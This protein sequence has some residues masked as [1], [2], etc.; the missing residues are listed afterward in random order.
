MAQA[1]TFKVNSGSSESNLLARRKHLIPGWRPTW[2]GE[3]HLVRF[4][5]RSGPTQ[6]PQEGCWPHS[7]V[8]SS[9]DKA[10]SWRCLTGSPRHHT[11]RPP[12]LGDSHLHQAVKKRLPQ[13]V[14]FEGD[15]SLW[16]QV[17]NAQVPYNASHLQHRL[18]LQLVLVCPQILSQHHCTRP[19]IHAILWIKNLR[20]IHS[21]LEK[22][23]SKHYTIDAFMW[24]PRHV[25]WVLLYFLL[26][27]SMPHNIA[28]V[29][30]A[31]SYS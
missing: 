13:D 8:C 31:L 2:E 23:H 7:C 1:C 21:C 18:V 9:P 30:M 6:A 20:D 25:T 17:D 14:A 26:G 12:H 15:F 27:N 4:V 19:H 16:Q 5:P 22:S 29:W 10:A 3:Q 11:L 28:A 24:Q